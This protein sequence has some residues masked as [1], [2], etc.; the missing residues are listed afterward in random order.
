MLLYQYIDMKCIYCLQGK[1]IVKNS[2]KTKNARLVWRR[3]G[4]L[5]CSAVFTTKESPLGDNL[6]M[7]KRNS[8]RQ[9]FFYEKLLVSIVYAVERGKDNDRGNQA[10]LAKLI[11]EKILA[12]LFKKRSKEVQTSEITKLCYTLLYK[13]NRYFA[14]RYMHYSVYRENICS[15]L[16]VE[17]GRRS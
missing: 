14:E 1:T 15:P 10:K 8:R 13:E 2:R 16:R 5:S 17:F 6:F 11:A 3:R 7:V 4:C 12:A 9:R